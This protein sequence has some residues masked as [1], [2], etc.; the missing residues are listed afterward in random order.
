MSQLYELK[1]GGIGNFD[2]AW[3]EDLVIMMEF[4]TLEELDDLIFHLSEIKEIP[5]CDDELLEKAGGKISADNN[6]ASVNNFNEALNIIA[7]IIYSRMFCPM[8]FSINKLKKFIE[9]Y[10]KKA[11]SRGYKEE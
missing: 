2:E 10:K 7:K 8:D 1:K 6:E 4:L 11:F 3:K 9:P 5:N